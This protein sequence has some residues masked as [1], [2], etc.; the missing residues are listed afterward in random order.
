MPRSNFQRIYPKNGKIALDGGYNNKFDRSLINDNES[1][2]CLNVI[3]DNGRV[4]TRGGTSKLNT[5]SV[6]SYA[7]DG[8]Y[9]RH[10]SDGTETMVAWYGG[11]LYALSGTTFTTIASAQSIYTV[12]QQVYAAEYENYMFFGNGGSIPYK[13][14]GGEFTRHGIFS[15]VSAPAA[16][17]AATGTALTGD[18]RYKVTYI[19]SGAVESD[20]GPATTT[21]TAA[22]ENIALSD[23]PVAP[24][25]WGVA[26]RRIYRTKDGGSTY[27]RVDTIDDNTT[28]TYEDAIVDGS[29]VTEEPDDQGVPPNYSVIKYH[30]GRLFVIDPATNLVKYSEVGNPYVFKTLSFRRIGDTSGD[31]P[32]MLAVYN[33][34][35]VVGC[36][37]SMWIVYT[38]DATDT[39]WADI[40]VVTPYGCRAPL[41]VMEYNNKLMFAA[42][43]NG[44]FVG[45][46]ALSGS[47]IDPSVS[48]LTR[49]QLGSDLKSNVIED[50]MFLVPD[51]YQS[52]I[53]AISHRNRGYI[54]GPYGDGQ[55]TNNRIWY[56]DY[57]YEN[58][59]RKNK[60][61]WSPWSGLAAMQFTVYGNT[62]YYA[63]D[64][65]TGFV[66]A[67]NQSNAN[68]DGT[69][70]D[71]YIWTKEFFGYADNE[72]WVKD[73]RWL[74]LYYVLIGNGELDISLR[75][76]SSASSSTDIDSVSLIG[77]M[78]WDTSK[79]DNGIWNKSSSSEVKKIPLGRFRG[80]RIQI[81]FSNGNVADV[82]FKIIGIR[83]TYNL[84]GF[85]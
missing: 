77:P 35:L 40:Q 24:T 39:N 5:A 21:F 23:I 33:G 72:E 28:T 26:S 32:R 43:L 17:T 42:T 47:S 6:G 51:N 38:P 49:S 69:A 74:N 70:I 8:L 12:G 68:D 13:Y 56:F 27:F 29:L 9:T 10:D 54:S 14:A 75:I 52:K 25:S 30:Q 71:S 15:P 53:A 22:A 48:V 76:D 79:W 81:K 84:R 58:L 20:S 73:W 57:S 62:L 66:Y 64:A 36:E 4:Q 46:A 50:E 65:A 16:A 19:N 67:M 80:K 1:P 37:K 45:F 63:T 41:S 11:S 18:Y 83:M 2:D 78:V 82:K 31:I 44:D 60:F 3:Y 85:R 7:C 55:T 59:D 34:S 61:A